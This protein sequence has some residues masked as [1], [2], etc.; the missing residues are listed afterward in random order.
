MLE[1]TVARNEEL[2]WSVENFPF[3]SLY[4]AIRD[5][6]DEVFLEGFRDQIRAPENR[7][8]MERAAV[9]AIEQI[10]GRTNCLLAL[11]S[12]K[13]PLEL[14][15]LELSPTRRKDSI[16]MSL[17]LGGAAGRGRTFYVAMIHR[18]VAMERVRDALIRAQV[19]EEA[20]ARAAAERATAAIHAAAAARSLSF[21]G[22]E[23]VS[24]QHEYS[25]VTEAPPIGPIPRGMV[26]QRFLP[27]RRQTTGTGQGIAEWSLDTPGISGGS[28]AE[29]STLGMANGRPS[30][31][32]TLQDHRYGLEAWGADPVNASHAR[33]HGFLF[34]DD[35]GQPAVSDSNENLEKKM[36]TS[37]VFRRLASKQH[38]LDHVQGG[39]IV[40]ENVRQIVLADIEAGQL[41]S[42]SGA[43]IELDAE[44]QLS[45]QMSFVAN[46]PVLT[47]AKKFAGVL[48]A[49]TS[50]PVSIWDF[51][52][53]PE[54]K[55][56]DCLKNH[57]SFCDYIFGKGM[58]L[59]TELIAKLAVPSFK[60]AMS[61]D[62]VSA[63]VDVKR[64][65]LWHYLARQLTNPD[66]TTK[67]LSNYLWRPFWVERLSEIELNIDT[68]A[69]WRL[70]RP[71][72]AAAPSRISV[73]RSTNDKSE[74]K[75]KPQ[76]V[77]D[78]RE[79][80]ALR[81]KLR[82]ATRTGSGVVKDD[83]SSGSD[84]DS[85]PIPDGTQ[86]TKAIPRV[87]VNGVCLKHLVYELKAVAPGGSASAV[88]CPFGAHCRFDHDWKL[89]KKAG[90]LDQ[91]SRCSSRQL[92][93]SS[94]SLLEAAIKAS[95]EIS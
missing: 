80:R 27:I 46:M 15:E 7:I 1:S 84:S 87:A 24:N 36:A 48:G 88:V 90:L 43:N 47:S 22:T 17:A 11:E 53:R 70:L 21:E 79:I 60:Q 45:I 39:R 41:Y 14:P 26:E 38:I 8:D 35:N 67:D 85:D 89:W 25:R 54:D 44:K 50:E 34:I 42:I 77:G 69:R 91:V 12:Q 30:S 73:Q 51:K 19:A 61:D 63:M 66:G 75:R 5:D 55:L 3:D 9:F 83:P 18:A 65:S 82:R 56:V 33:A 86:K 95:K 78:D 71:K 64:T 74:R 13:S 68:Q 81:E 58:N 52:A 49:D 29:R 76:S 10:G 2:L 28:S 93:P 59:F 32:S 62:Y 92:G 72:P 23:R 31:R 40:P 94:K 6:P 37:R 16:R 57:E 4:P 20:E